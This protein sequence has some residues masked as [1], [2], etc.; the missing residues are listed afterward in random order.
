M[1][2][3]IQQYERMMRYIQ[4]RERV[5]DMQSTVKQEIQRSRSTPPKRNLRKEAEAKRRIDLENQRLM[6]SL[7][8]IATRPNGPTTTK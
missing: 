8:S 4:H 1:A 2:D 5:L 6:R 3:R 7:M